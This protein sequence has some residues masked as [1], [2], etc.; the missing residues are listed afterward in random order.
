[1]LEANAEEVDD[2]RPEPLEV[3][4]RPAPQRVVV[5]EPALAHEARHRRALDARRARGSRGGRAMRRTP[6]WTPTTVDAMPPRR[7]AAAAA[8]TRHGSRPRRPQPRA[9]ARQVLHPHNLGAGEPRP[10]GHGAAQR[11]GRDLARARSRPRQLA[12]AQRA[13]RHGCASATPRTPAAASRSRTACARGWRR[14][15]T[16]PSTSRRPSRRRR[17][18]TCSTAASTAA[19]PG[20]SC[21]G[22]QRPATGRR[23][24][25]RGPDSARRHRAVGPGGLD[26]HPRHGDVRRR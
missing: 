3:L 11:D 9:A 4:D 13:G 17:R 8:A 6:Y 15:V 7:F 10:R 22:N 26:R 20:A 19:A 14:P 24:V 21:A 2:R 1:M 12:T 18:A 16:R 25:V 5:L 23:A